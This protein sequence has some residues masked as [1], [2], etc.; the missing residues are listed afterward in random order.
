MELKR[1][2][3]SSSSLELVA[4]MEDISGTREPLLVG[5]KVRLNSGGPVMLV[6]DVQGEHITAAVPDQEY[7]FRRPCLSLID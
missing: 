5:D 7:S 3:F 4:R 2:A 1:R 6:V